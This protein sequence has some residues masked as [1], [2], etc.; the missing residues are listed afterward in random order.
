ME[1]GSRFKRQQKPWSSVHL[2]CLV[3]HC[4]ILH[5]RND[6]YVNK[7]KSRLDDSTYIYVPDKRCFICSR[8]NNQSDLEKIGRGW[9][10]RFEG[11]ILLAYPTK[12]LHF[13][14]Q[15]A[16]ALLNYKRSSNTI[17]D[18][19]PNSGIFADFL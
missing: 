8:I 16:A 6:N 19:F 4:K 12:H 13:T 17:A 9:R 18:L 10:R 2:Q 15:S 1:V 3:L 7:H 14:L 5:Q 11:I